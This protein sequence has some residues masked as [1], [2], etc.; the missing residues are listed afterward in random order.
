[1]PVMSLWGSGLQVLWWVIDVFSVHVLSQKKRS[2]TAEFCQQ[3]S[4]V[5]TIDTTS[6]DSHML[7]HPLDSPTL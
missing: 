7:S 6:L 2:V 1:M 5:F 4:L 3:T